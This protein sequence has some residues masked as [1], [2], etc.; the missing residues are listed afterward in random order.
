MRVAEH[1]LHLYTNR[2]E[3]VID[4]ILNWGTDVLVNANSVELHDFETFRPVDQIADRLANREQA[5]G[6][7]Q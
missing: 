7:L 6:Q 1:K 2:A 3:A 4:A 5:T